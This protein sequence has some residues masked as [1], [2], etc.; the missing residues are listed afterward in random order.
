MASP[1]EWYRDN[2]L[3]STSP[4]LIQPTAVNA[5]FATEAL[6]WARPMEESLLK[7]MLDKSL[8][9]GVYELP[10]LASDIAGLNC[11]PLR[12]IGILFR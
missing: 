10:S 3:I 12:I 5:A 8:C 9:F 11:P 4:S 6:Y 2:Y 1:M 7:K